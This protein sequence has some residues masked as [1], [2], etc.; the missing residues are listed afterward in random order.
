MAPSDLHIRLAEPDDLDA[1]VALEEEIFPT[2]WSR[3]SLA[4]ELEPDRGRH[5]VLALKGGVPVGF[6]LVWA[7]ADELHM[8]TLG[9]VP[10][11]RRQ[12]IAAA[13]LEWVLASPPAAL[14][15]IMTLEVREQ[16]EAARGLYR[17]FGFREVAIRPR[18]Y[19]DT[20][21]DAIVMLRELPG[22]SDPWTD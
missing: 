11:Q 4:L 15:R 20:H 6:A 22:A 9:V 3:A 19:P 8:V 7:V 5:P 18:Y 17:R 21:E 12:G 13:I 10:A 16:N 14:S 2:P 1:I